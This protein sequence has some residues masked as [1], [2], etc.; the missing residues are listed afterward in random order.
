MPAVIGPEQAVEARF[1]QRRAVRTPGGFDATE[2]CDVHDVGLHVGREPVRRVHQVDPE[3][4]ERYT[5]CSFSD[6]QS[7]WSVR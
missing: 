7:V 4:V 3:S 5:P 2:L 6:T 1:E